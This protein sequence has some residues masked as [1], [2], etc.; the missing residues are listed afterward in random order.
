MNK[1]LYGRDK[2]ILKLQ[3]LIVTPRNIPENVAIIGVKG[4]GKT[5]LLSKLFS[6]EEKKKYYTDHKLLL[7]FVDIPETTEE[8][9]DFYSYLYSSIMEGAYII[10]NFNSSEYEKIRNE[11]TQEIERQ[12]QLSPYSSPDE[13]T[14]DSIVRRTLDIL[15]RHD[16]RVLFIIDNFEKL[17]RSS[18]IKNAQY[19]YMRDLAN[20]EKMSMFIS[21]GQDL[22]KVS[23]E[24][25]GSGFENIFRF[26]NIPGIDE[27]GIEDWFEAEQLS[28][29]E[30][31]INKVLDLTGGVPELIKIYMRLSEDNNKV[32]SDDFFDKMMIEAES[33]MKMWNEY[34]DEEEKNKLQEVLENNS[35]NSSIRDR[36]LMKGLLVEVNTNNIKFVTPL[37]EEYIKKILGNQ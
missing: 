29:N 32:D 1:Q 16:L 28:N 4:V 12:K 5:S 37:F 18:R 36:L 9:K 24:I 19:K 23:E 7:S 17:A 14:M 15:N 3:N 13:A 20:N 2:L 34:I 27:Y 26:V 11:I 8:M 6:E 10:N 21:S 30:E 22:T 31:V 25:K 33:L 35:T